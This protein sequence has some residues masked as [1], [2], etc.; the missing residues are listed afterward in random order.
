MKHN[1]IINGVECY[2][3]ETY[4]KGKKT[5]FLVPWKVKGMSFFEFA[6][7][8][9]AK[10]SPNPQ[11]E[12]PFL[13]LMPVFY[14]T[15]CYKYLLNERNFDLFSLSSPYYPS[16]R[17]LS[18]NIQ[19]KPTG[20]LLLDNV[21]K[22]VC[23][24]SPAGGK[25]L[26][27]MLHGAIYKYPD[28]VPLWSDIKNIDEFIDQELEKLKKIALK[29]MAERKDS[30]KKVLQEILDRYLSLC[31]FIAE[32]V[33]FEILNEGMQAVYEI[34][35]NSLSPGERSLFKL[36]CFK[37]PKYLN[38]IISFDPSPILSSFRHI[39]AMIY[40]EFGIERALWLL[41]DT[42]VGAL[43]LTYI[44][45]YPAWLR[46][47]QDEEA[48]KDQQKKKKRR[49]EISY[50]PLLDGHIPYNP[51]Y[52]VDPH[53]R[54]SIGLGENYDKERA[55]GSR[56]HP[57][58]TKKE[59][60]ILFLTDF[61]R[62]ILRFEAE[63]KLSKD[64]AQLLSCSPSTISKEQKK[65]EQTLHQSWE[66][67]IWRPFL[68]KGYRTIKKVYDQLSPTEKALFR[69]FYFAHVI[70]PIREIY[71]DTNFDIDKLVQEFTP[72]FLR[73]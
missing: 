41:D 12:A 6:I 70:D 9:C 47:V 35:E 10:D 4:F 21:Q 8:L 39:L 45:F 66:K 69:D 18:Q 46:L 17:D 54:A 19:I 48:E 16:L 20:S 42:F 3:A 34:I 13:I 56:K 49:K 36:I 30:V 62:E 25:N 63:G 7:T 26:N 52:E 51:E 1:I 68:K 40:D 57:R 2:I 32:Q 55:K 53:S 67:E 28:R 37:N 11:N 44:N 61:Q 31:C 50:H 59:K 22:M 72:P 33:T 64:I 27:E 15:S 23:L 43:F 5:R 38:R 58:K 29:I 24:G 60:V 71:K 73:K 14:Y 65:I